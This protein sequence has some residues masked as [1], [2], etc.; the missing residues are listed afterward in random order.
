VCRH[1]GQYP[2]QE[3]TAEG[4]KCRV[5]EAAEIVHLTA[6]HDEVIKIEC[7]RQGQWRIDNLRIG[8]EG[9]ADQQKKRNDEADKGNYKYGIHNDVA[10]DPLCSH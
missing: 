3:H 5:P 1:G 2:N 6:R 4:D 8:L 10:Q 7:T 9:I